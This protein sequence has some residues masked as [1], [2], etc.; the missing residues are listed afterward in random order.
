MIKGF[1]GMNISSKDPKRLVEFYN[2]VLGIPILENDENYDGVFLGFIENAPLIRIWDENNWGKSNEGPVCLVFDCDDHEKT[3]NEIKLK[4]AGVNPP[5]IASWGGE[6]ME[7]KDP[8]G[9]NVYI[10]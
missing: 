1:R 7:F 2:E 9:N 6:K 8:D 5:F 10:L 3:Y 4:Y